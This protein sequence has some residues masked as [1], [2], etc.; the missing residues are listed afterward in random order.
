MLL[1]TWLYIFAWGGSLQTIFLCFPSTHRLS[2]DRGGSSDHVA[3]SYPHVLPTSLQ[4]GGTR[5]AF[6][7]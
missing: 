1:Q 3:P 5:T 4:L 2:G 6:H 7:L